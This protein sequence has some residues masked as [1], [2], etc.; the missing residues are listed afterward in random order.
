MSDYITTIII[1]GGIWAVLAVSLNLLTG[2]AGQVS[3][4]QAA[5]FAIGAYTSALV[6]IRMNLPFLVC[7]LLS[8]VVAGVLTGALGLLALRVRD[9]FLV[10]TTIGVNFLVVALFQNFKVFGATLGL[11]GMPFAEIGGKLLTP[12]A[13]AVVVGLSL[14]VVCVA[15]LLLRRTWLG[16]GFTALREDEQAARMVGI[17]TRAFKVCAFA[18]S[19]TIAGLAGGLYAFYLGSVFPQNFNFIISIQVMAMLVLGGLGTLRGAVVGALILTA[20]PELLRPLADYRYTIFG[21]VLVIV[22]MFVPDGLAGLWDRLRTGVKLRIRSTAD[23]RTTSSGV[24]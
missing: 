21:A 8:A 14:A 7:L 10:F 24:S 15:A 23:S 1:F 19:G 20:L 5:F 9:D 13:F 2:E 11:V 6:A 3:L 4:G 16:T 22:V 17:P 18:I 12:S